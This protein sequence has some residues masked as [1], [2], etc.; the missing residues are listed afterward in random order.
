M[1]GKTPIEDATR[2]PTSSATI[3][4]G[5]GGDVE[6][7]GEL[8]L[9][10]KGPDGCQGAAMIRWMGSGVATLWFRPLTRRRAYFASETGVPK[11]S[12]YEKVVFAAQYESQF[13]QASHV[14]G[15]STAGTWELRY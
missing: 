13:I 10:P 8:D 3:I 15:D 2:T 12:Y 1:S 14:H 4:V 5:S 7:G 6:A 9:R 11:A